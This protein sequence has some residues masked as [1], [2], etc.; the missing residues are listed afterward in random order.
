[1]KKLFGKKPAEDMPRRRSFDDAAKQSDV[2]VPAFPTYRRN[3][4]I[5]GSSSAQVASSNELNAELRSP[6]AHVHHLSRRRRTVFGHFTLA[7][8]AGLGLYILMSQMIASVAVSAGSATLLPERQ[9]QYTNKITSYFER[10]PL[11]RLLFN[12]SEEKLLRYVASEYPE[13]S[14]VHLDTSGIF[15]RAQAYISLRTPIAKWS[16]RGVNE[17]VDQQGV[18]F[19]YNGYDAP[20]LQIVDSTGATTASGLVTSNRFLAFVGRVVGAV[21]SQGYTV[22]EATIPPLT[23]RQL[24]VK[25]DGV[26]YRIK[27]TLDRSAGEQA[28]DMAR[29]STFLKGK[30][31]S[32]AYLDVRVEGRAVYK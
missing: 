12:V 25:V 1:M 11:E 22:T 26:P 20:T 27:F 6:R 5:T 28:E 9:A 16:L 3:R 29:T 13:I 32:P 31:A 14:K 8:L 24:E 30:G 4:T 2:E 18:V 17:F 7:L 23:T 10:N 19:A 21:K 15:G